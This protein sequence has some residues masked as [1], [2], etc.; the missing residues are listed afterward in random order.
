MVSG[1]KLGTITNIVSS[2]LA[3]FALTTVYTQ[4]INQPV[5]NF[6]KI[7]DENGTYSIEFTNDGI[8]S[9]T[10][11]IL[12]I[13]SPVNI[14]NYEVFST[15]DWAE[16]KKDDKSLSIHFSRL[17]QGGGSLTK[18]KIF[19][20]TNLSKSGNGYVAYA[21][22]DQGSLRANSG[23][24]PTVVS[25]IG[26]LYSLPILLIIFAIVSFSLSFLY[27]RYKRIAAR[28]SQS[29]TTYAKAVVETRG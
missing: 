19:T 12:T 1:G 11:F 14:N 6:N 17:A 5:I 26:T 25:P 7:T 10:N 9:A 29:K 16:G 23:T 2:G 18:I 13:E 4:V 21:T 15:E 20:D 27:R 22:Y 3:V 28:T 8:A 24:T